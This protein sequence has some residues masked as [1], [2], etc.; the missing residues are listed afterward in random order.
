MTEKDWRYHTKVKVWHFHKNKRGKDQPVQCK[1]F[2]KYFERS[3][4]E[5]PKCGEVIVYLSGVE[6]FAE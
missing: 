2:S 5:C 1:L 6:V 4:W 3:N